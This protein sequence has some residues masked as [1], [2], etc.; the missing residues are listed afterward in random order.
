MSRF[1]SLKVRHNII[2]A[3]AVAGLVAA[4]VG[5]IGLYKIS[6]V[7]DSA[8][9]MYSRALLPAADAADLRES[10]WQYRF[11]GA[12]V[13][14]IID[15]AVKAQF[16]ASREAAAARIEESAQRF[17]TRDLDAA[18]RNTINQFNTTWGEYKTLLKQAQDL[19]AAGKT[20]E[21]QP[22]L[23]KQ[24]A[25]KAEEAIKVLGTLAEVSRATAQAR[26]AD[27]NDARNQAR[28]LV[29]VVLIGGL[30]LAIAV[31]MLLAQAILRPLLQVR[32]VLTA[33]GEGDLTRETQFAADNE[34]GQMAAALSR[35]TTRMRTA[36]KTL[37]SSSTSLAARADEL[38]NA[39]RGL[40]DG[41]ER[42]AGEVSKI[43]G[44]SHEV[45]NSVQAVASG[46]EEM[47]ASI[48]EIAVSTSEAASVA[49]QAVDASAAAE[50]IMVR[51]GSSS[52]EIGDV[53]K[54]I[55]SIAEQ[56]NLL[57]LNATIEAAR[58]GEAGKGFAVVAGEVKDLA[59][60]TA[61]ATEEIGQRVRAIQTDTASAVESISEIARVIGRINEYQT[62]IAS[63]V[64]ELERGH[65]QHGGRPERGGERRGPH[66]RRHRRGGARRG[67]HDARRA[68][69]PYG[70][71]G[72]DEHVGGVA[73]DRRRLQ[74]LIAST[75]IWRR[76]VRR[77]DRSCQTGGGATSRTISG[78]GARGSFGLWASGDDAVCPPPDPAL[79]MSDQPCCPRAL[80]REW[81][82]PVTGVAGRLSAQPVHDSDH[83]VHAVVAV[84]RVVAPTVEV[85]RAVVA[86]PERR[87]LGW[88]A[89]MIS[90]RAACGS[91]VTCSTWPARRPRCGTWPG[92]CGPPVTCSSSAS[93]TARWSSSAA[94]AHSPCSCVVGRHCTSAAPLTPLPCCGRR[95]RSWPTRPTPPRTRTGRHRTGTSKHSR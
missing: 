94:T 10:V 4:A 58:A 73:V 84:E 32:D 19:M 39:S 28:L 85:R 7:A 27:A 56:T 23:I 74:A 15:P 21:A 62:T 46:A 11:F 89:W 33:V 78:S 20:V 88:A 83:V 64:E 81:I 54:V 35:A 79:P 90:C 60:E 22:V 77:P 87:A 17:T 34:L 70:G 48:R 40:A 14:T 41:D 18:Q 44:S 36:V 45:S 9:A 67:Q 68:G 75:P 93:A 82:S 65:D 16:N 2:I 25:P 52:A 38:Q 69:D 57:A 47:N 12:A 63:A 92:G 50:Q 72:A 5:G 37:A 8:D 55:T 76:R 71:G 24:V 13:N 29:A 30:I 43:S 80:R 31:A 49:G 66:Q 86:A 95:S 61:K 91:R 1:A 3:V 51:L 59:Q 53:I 42:T 6:Q 26:L